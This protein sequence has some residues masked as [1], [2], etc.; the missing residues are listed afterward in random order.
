MFC[1]LEMIYRAVFGC[2]IF[3]KRRKQH[4]EPFPFKIIG[5]GNLTVGG[6]GKSVFIGF[7]ARF[8]KN[9]VAIVLRGYKGT[10][11]SARFSVLVS[12]GQKNFVTPD[13]SGD[14]AFMHATG[15]HVPVVI[16]KSRY[17]S[18]KLVEKLIGQRKINSSYVLLDDAYQHFSVKKDVEILLVDARAPFDNGHCLPCGR[19]REKDYTRADIIIATHADKVSA[20]QLLSIKTNLFPRTMPQN[21]FF[22]K[23]VIDGFY[24]NNEQRQDL[25]NIE[26][27]GFVLV[28]GVG[29]FASVVASIKQQGLKIA[30]EKP[31]KNHYAYT[32]EDLMTLCVCAKK[33]NLAGIVTTEKDW[34]KIQEFKQDL[35]VPFYVARV[36]FEFSNPQEYDHF[37]RRMTDL[38]Q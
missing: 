27:I 29:N 33:S 15:R 18:C 17:K 20:Q 5:V 13:C 14:E 38:L 4:V 26:N 7:L 36:G 35:T 9:N 12:D 30:L 10:S 32:K 19:L 3:F 25:K 2:A 8:F 23:H 21:I 11:S 16:G 1:I 24:L 22:G 37:T 6:T 31:F 28:A 34:V